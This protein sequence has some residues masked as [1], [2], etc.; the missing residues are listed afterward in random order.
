ML[1]NISETRLVHDEKL[2]Y[3]HPCILYVSLVVTTK[4]FNGESMTTSLIREHSAHNLLVFMRH[5]EVYLHEIV[6]FRWEK[7][8]DIF[9]KASQLKIEFMR[10]FGYNIIS[11]F[12]VMGKHFF[13]SDH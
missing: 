1:V 11:F 9:I 2:I 8:E 10:I 4:E 12:P 5:S 6:T 7:R 3:H 13:P